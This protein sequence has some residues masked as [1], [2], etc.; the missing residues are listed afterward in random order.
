MRE[1]Q[2]PPSL[3]SSM[4]FSPMGN[5]I[6]FVDNQKQ[7][8]LRPIEDLDQLLARGCRWLQQYYFSNPTVRQKK[9]SPDSPDERSLCS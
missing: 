9:R 6:L 4:S 8:Q 2:T 5:K 7:L 1:F 3:N